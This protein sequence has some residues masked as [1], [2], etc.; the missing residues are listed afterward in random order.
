MADRALHS[1]NRV[2]IRPGR[3]PHAATTGRR[4]ARI[5]GRYLGPALDRALA[6]VD[7]D[8]TVERVVVTFPADPDELDDEAVAMLWASLV[9]DSLERIRGTRQPAAANEPT[10]EVA[11][12]ANPRPRAAAQVDAQELAAV[13]GALQRWARDGAPL[14]PAELD[15]AVQRPGLADRAVAELSEPWRAAARQL[16]EEAIGLRGP[17]TRAAQDPADGE[18]TPDLTGRLA[19]GPVVLP[20]AG[21]ASTT[22]PAPAEAAQRPTPP[23]YAGTAAMPPLAPAETTGVAVSS[24]GGLVLLHYRLRAYLELAAD[25]EASLDALAV[26]AAALKLLTGEPAAVADPI[27]R[28]LAGDPDWSASGDER[29]QIRWRDPSAAA[30]RAEGLLQ[31]F[32]SDLPGFAASSAGFVR[33]QWVRRRAL[34]LEDSPAVLIT[35]ERRP[36]DLVLDRLPYPIG[37]LRLPWTPSLFIGWERP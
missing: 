14:T 20:G 18:E 16:V 13:L 24:W 30:A 32:A 3:G 34:L 12:P 4:L 21:S 11:D 29:D 23:A 9:R 33:G 8:L 26:R 10:A 27:T 22:T 35:L 36:L 2:R 15:L 17:A 1:V 6:D 7:G 25:D 5:A 31:Q 19:A 28:L 37:A